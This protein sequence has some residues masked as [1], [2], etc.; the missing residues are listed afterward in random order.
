MPSCLTKPC[1]A[2]RK[3]YASAPATP[4]A[5]DDDALG[6]GRV[7][8]GAAATMA[9]SPVP[10]LE[11]A[12]CPCASTSIPSPAASSRRFFSRA[13]T[14]GTRARGPA[15]PPLLTLAPV[16][17]PATCAAR[18]E[19]SRRSVAVRCP[20][21]DASSSARPLPRTGQSCEASYQP[22]PRPG[23]STRTGLRKSARPAASRQ[24]CSSVA[25]RCTDCSVPAA[26][27]TPTRPS[28]GAPSGP[29]PAP[30]P[31]G[32]PRP[33][34]PAGKAASHKRT[35]MP[36]SGSCV[37]GG[38]VPAAGVSSNAGWPSALLSAAG[39]AASPVASGASCWA[40]DCD[41]AVAATP[42]CAK[43]STPLASAEP[44]SCR[45]ARSSIGSGP[46]PLQGP[47][48]ALLETLPDL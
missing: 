14:A 3:P 21:S 8:E 2:A 39:P 16:M 23:A 4:P 34:L 19:S 32:A 29:A 15:R 41:A 5:G 25:G 28:A 35:R 10:L 9:T 48:A 27:T 6:A 36:S 31:A 18:P 45:G 30:E 24:A 42:E 37:L 11:A 40:R 47:R 26:T 20:S 46:I 44:A 22:Q 43:S 7:T 13:T 17:C 38:A 12:A 1:S 33:A